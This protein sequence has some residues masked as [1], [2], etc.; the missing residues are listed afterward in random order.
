MK[1]KKEA[2]GIKKIY[3]KFFLLKKT[4]QLSELNVFIG[5]RF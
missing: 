5:L 2:S 1:K 4:T 3:E